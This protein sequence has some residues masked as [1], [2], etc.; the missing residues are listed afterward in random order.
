MIV[1][2]RIS[3]CDYH[4]LTSSSEDQRQQII[5]L[6]IENGADYH[7]DL[8]K[9]ITHLIAFKPE[10]A[11][12]KYAKSWGLQIVSLEWLY[13]GAKRGMILDEKLY[14]PEWP[15]SERGKGAWVR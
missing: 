15:V 3:M 4:P 11:K 13:D 1:C 2:F 7:G 8:T 14:N 12:Y 6:V 9:K 5:N 10:G